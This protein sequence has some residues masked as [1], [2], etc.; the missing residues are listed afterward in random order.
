[1]KFVRRG[2]SLFLRKRVPVRYVRIETR[3]IVHI[4][5]HTDSEAIAAQKA[6]RV[7]SEMID[8]WEAKLKGETGTAAD[9]FAAARDLAHLRGYRYLPAS[10]IA[11]LPISEILDRTEAAMQSGKPGQP[12]DLETRALLGLVPEPALTVT[13]ALHEY[14]TAAEDRKRG[15]SADQI[16]RWQNPR[17]KAVAN[18]VKAVGDRPLADISAQDMRDFRAWWVRKVEDDDLTPNSANKDFTHL[19]DMLASVVEAMNLSLDLPLKSLKQLKDDEK[20]T[21]P[22]FSVDWIRDRLLAPGALDG[23]NV[24]ARC[25][26]LGMVNTGCRPSELQNLTAAQI[27]LDD[28]VP[29]LSIEGVGRTLKSR[30]ARRRIP[31]VGI[32]LA[33]FE[34]CPDG[35][36]RYRD[37]PGLSA[38]INS[39]L[40]ENGLCETEAHTLYCLRHSFEDR[41]IAAGVDPR[42]RADLFG[43]ALDRERYGAGASLQQARDILQA[44]AL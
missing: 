16:R 44:F 37:K 10:A 35:F 25:I 7:W 40:R 2:K 31:L 36:P 30:N 34:Q 22:P 27:R 32:S 18:F 17:K 5:L 28:P 19:K 39:Y 29:H 6:P 23:M 1:M 3:G 8:A 13:A 43:H 33:A 11:R 12:D 38:T 9:L 26:L 42:I 15:K 14:W 21:R 20:R 4:S 41:M 24:E